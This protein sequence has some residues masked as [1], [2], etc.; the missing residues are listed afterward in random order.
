[1]FLVMIVAVV[2]AAVTAAFFAFNESSSR[3]QAV[4]PNPNGYDDFAA[5]SQWMVAWNGDLLKLP[6]EEIANAVKQNSKLLEAVHTGLKKQSAVPVANDLNWFTA[7]MAQV[8]PH[9]SVAQL[10]VGEGIVRLAMGRTNEA[11][12]CFA[13]SIVFAHAAHRQGLLID[14]LVGIACQAIGAP[15]L[16]QIAAHLSPDNRREILSQLIALDQSRE[17][18]ATIIQ[19]DRE[20]GRQTYGW[21]RSA[22]AQIATRKSVRAAE[23]QFEKRHTHSV[24]ALRLVMT[25]LAVRG[26]EAKSGRPPKTLGDLVPEWLPAVP[27]DPFSNQPLVYRLTTNSFLLYSLGPDA[28]DNQGTPIKRGQTETGDLLPTAL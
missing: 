28:Q 20:W 8:G 4:L 15:R 9:R 22:W 17:A 14:D 13:D 26:Y 16:V 27:L 18:A 12:K 2:L 21:L 23:M 6:P 24:A 7:H 3:Q 19:R 1:M 25:E 10:L 11:A 5:A